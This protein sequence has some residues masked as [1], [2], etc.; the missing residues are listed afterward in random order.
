M[1]DPT[2]TTLELWGA[3]YQ[4]NNAILCKMEDRNILEEI[5]KRERCPITFVGVVTGDGFVSLIESKAN[6]EEEWTRDKLANMKDIPFDMHLKEI[7]GDMPRKEFHLQRE[8]KILS[9]LNI[10]SNKNF[11]GFVNDVLSVMSVGSKRFLTNKVDRCVTGLI[12]QQQ[13][14]GPL[15]TPLCDYAVTAVSYFSFEGIATS[16]GTQPLK[17]LI[18]AKSGARMSVAEAISNLVFVGISEL[19]DVKCSGNWMWAAKLPGQ[20]ALLYDACKEMC[21]IMKE[22]NIAVD[23]GKDSLSMAARVK[24]LSNFIFVYNLTNL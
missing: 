10:P 24:G 1:G 6:F 19:A 14:V 13:C 3:E 15:H 2:I 21:S 8:E 23:G 7:L 5:C 18:T 16:I 4:E 22:L 12:A 20:G 11:S 17:G 9:N